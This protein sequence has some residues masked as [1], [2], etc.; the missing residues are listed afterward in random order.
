VQRS[1]R[2]R[3]DVPVVNEERSQA[4]ARTNG[5]GL[6]GKTI[7]TAVCIDVQSTA[8]LVAALNREQTMLRLVGETSHPPLDCPT[9][10]Y[11]HCNRSEAVMAGSSHHF[12]VTDARTPSVVAYQSMRC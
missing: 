10:T 3:E 11:S 7:S 12:D 5:V 8:E 9:F 2:S 1:L 4:A 6:E